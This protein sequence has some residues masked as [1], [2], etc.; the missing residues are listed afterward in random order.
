MIKESASKGRRFWTCGN[1]RECEFFE[2]MDGVP[3]G[4]VA[5]SSRQAPSVVP[6]KRTYPDR[7]VRTLTLLDMNV[8]NQR[9]L[10]RWQ[11]QDAVLDANPLR[12]CKCNE[13]AVQR[14]VVKEGPNKGRVFWVCPNPQDTRP[15]CDFFEWDD[16]PPRATGGGNASA[17]GSQGAGQSGGE[18]YKVLFSSFFYR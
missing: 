13:N 9:W 16:E 17:V 8:L 2:W 10:Y 1:N 5:S 4:P 11:R 3:S 14:T 7:S 15:R 6:A 18:C 12:Q